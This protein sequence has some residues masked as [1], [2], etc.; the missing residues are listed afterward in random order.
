MV[1]SRSPAILLLF[2]MFKVKILRYDNP[3]KQDCHLSG[4]ISFS[5]FRILFL[6]LLL[7]LL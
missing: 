2:F 7:F 3:Y 6:L 4:K 5:I 1:G